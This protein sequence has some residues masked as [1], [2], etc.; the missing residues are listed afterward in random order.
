MS[1]MDTEFVSGL[2]DAAIWLV[3]N[4][5]VQPGLSKTSALLQNIYLIVT[6]VGGPS[7]N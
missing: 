7:F 6:I 2:P 5:M 3:Y 4:G 1:T